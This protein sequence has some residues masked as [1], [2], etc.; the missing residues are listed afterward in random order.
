MTSVR[1]H[2]LRACLV[3]LAERTYAQLIELFKD[4][5]PERCDLMV[6]ALHEASTVCRQLGSEL[7]QGDPPT[8]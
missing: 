6:R 3:E 2:E 1:A 8:V 5:T 7:T 4:A